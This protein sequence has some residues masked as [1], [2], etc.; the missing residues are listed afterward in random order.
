MII[1]ER[2][3]GHLHPLL[4]GLRDAPAGESAFWER[5]ADERTPLVEPDPASPG[6][7]LV[8]YVFRDPDAAHVV[9]DDSRFTVSPDF[10]MERIPGTGVWHAAYRYR[11]DVRAT[12]TF[13]SNLPLVS[14]MDAD[15]TKRT[16]FREFLRTVPPT[17]DP[18]ARETFVSHL[19]G[20]GLPDHVGSILSLPDAPDQT[21]LEERAEIAHGRV[22]RHQ[23]KSEVLSNERR[24]WVYTPPG[25]A[26]GKHVYPMLV[27]FD[28]AAALSI[29]LTHRILDNLLDDGHIAPTIAVF[30]DNAS[31]TSRTVELPCSEAFA[32]FIE[33][34]LLPWVRE[35]YAVSHQARNGFVT[36]TSY[37]G[38]ASLWLGFRLPHLFGNVISQS[39]SLWW[40]PGYDLEKPVPLQSYTPE[41]L[42][43]QYERASRL[44]LRIWMEVGL[45]ELLEPGDR[46]LGTNRR[47]A[48]VLREKGY[49]LTYSEFAAGH[50]WS[51]WRVSLA[52]AL[53][54]LLPAP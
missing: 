41:W 9:F 38:L 34:E 7:S 44:P 40:G 46:M 37:G 23:L 28:G 20:E 31:D 33:I 36:G 43:D 2:V 12:Y 25:Y 11:N 5:M 10:V 4:T 42:I 49:E 16:A 15:Q 26:P 48:A 3:R 17:S 45:M 18:N 39:A 14:S 1:A 6:Y 53:A 21:I 54:V 30:V 32:R 19:E 27:V 29:L 50:D 52:Q 47:M 35:R 24:I 8:T 51:H 22:E 13:T